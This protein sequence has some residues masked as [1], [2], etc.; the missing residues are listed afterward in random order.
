[1]AAG[2]GIGRGSPTAFSKTD[3]YRLFSSG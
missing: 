1:M 2:L 3:D